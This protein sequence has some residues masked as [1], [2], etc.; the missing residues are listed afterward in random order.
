MAQKQRMGSLLKAFA[1][2]Q[3]HNRWVKNTT[4]AQRIP[5]SQTAGPEIWLFAPQEPSHGVLDRLE[6]A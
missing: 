5:F 4:P 2:Q 1:R 3:Q 6:G